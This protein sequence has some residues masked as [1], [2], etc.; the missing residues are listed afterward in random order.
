MPLTID[1]TIADINQWAQA[2]LPA[3][4]TQVVDQLA[5]GSLQPVPQSSYPEAFSMPPTPATGWPY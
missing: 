5:D 4:M 2:V 3:M 1:T